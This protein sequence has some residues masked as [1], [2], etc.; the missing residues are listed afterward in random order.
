MWMQE[1]LKEFFFHCVYGQC[2][3]APILFGF[4]GLLFRRASILAVT[5]TD[6]ELRDDRELAV[7]RRMAK[8]A[9]PC[10]RP[11]SCS[12]KKI[13]EKLEEDVQRIFDQNTRDYLWS[14]LRRL[15]VS[16]DIIP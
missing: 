10:E 3:N 14:C 11:G 9:N 2:C 6:E 13:V 1:F 15:R 8:L 7:R 4:G 16:S 5:Y 12:Y